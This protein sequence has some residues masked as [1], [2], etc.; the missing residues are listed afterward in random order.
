MLNLKV[1]INYIREHKLT[2]EQFC[3]KCKITIETLDGIVYY[4]EIID[5]KTSERIAKS[6]GIGVYELFCY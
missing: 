1:I 3:Q 5:F 2:K 4:G 6:M